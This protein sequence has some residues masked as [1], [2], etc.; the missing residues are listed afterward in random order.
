M[1]WMDGEGLVHDKKKDEIKGKKNKEYL[2]NDRKTAR[3]SFETLK[4]DFHK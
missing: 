4:S 3:E 2:E 1:G